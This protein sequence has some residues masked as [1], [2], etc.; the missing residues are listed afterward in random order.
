[1]SPFRKLLS[2]NQEKNFLILENELFRTLVGPASEV[3]GRLKVGESVRID[4][5]VI[6]DI[7]SAA[8]SSPTVAIAS[9]GIVDGDV[10]AHR[11]LVAGRVSGSIQA[12][13]RVELVAG[14]VVEGNIWAKSV[15]MN[16]GATVKGLI[17]GQNT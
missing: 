17:T 15:G 14:S 6:G 13:D 1:M 12:T 7:E 8:G 16:H 11:V 2:K 4:G 9:S 10:I 5:T 3:H